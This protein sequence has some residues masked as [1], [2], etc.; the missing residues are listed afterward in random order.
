VERVLVFAPHPDDDIIG[1]GG[2]MA[3]HV[4]AGHEVAVVYMTSGE[5]G[6]TSYAKEELARLREGEARKAL[7]LL[8][9][10]RLQFLRIADG[11]IEFTKDTILRLMEIIRTYKPTVI[12]LPHSQEAV[13]DHA[14]TC[15]LV[16]EAARRAAGPWFQECPGEP[17]SVAKML[18]YEVWTPLQQVNYV[19][20]IDAYIDLK[21]AALEAHASQTQIV[22][23]H[24]AVR[25]LNRY[26]GVMT[27][28][29]R[30]CECFQI[31]TWA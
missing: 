16:C 29:G 28:R 25:G 5:A 21:I 2:S 11:C 8:G 15:R 24:E 1:C 9:I 31:I 13:S 14:L 4:Q 26:R 6:S 17:W 30:Y 3:G 7:S 18:A 10:N 22:Q 12:Y 19:N 23:Y 27:G 20:N